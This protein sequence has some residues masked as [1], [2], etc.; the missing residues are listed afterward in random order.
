[1]KYKSLSIILLLG[2]LVGCYS[3]PAQEPVHKAENVSAPI[4][5]Q[6][7]VTAKDTSLQLTRLADATFGELKQP[8]ERQI[9]VF[10]DPGKTFQTMVG[11]GG[12]LT[13]ASA[14]VFAKLPPAVQQDFLTAYY[15]KEKGIGYNFARTNIGSCDFSSDSYGYVQE[16]DSTLQTF[17]LAHDEKYKIPFIKQAMTAAGGRL[18]LF[19]SPWSP[20]AWMKD[21][22]SLLHGGKLLKRF[23]QSWANHY[24]KFIQSYEA[25]GIPIWGLSVQNEP[26]AVQK[27]ES[28]V[29]NAEDERDFVKNYLGPTL[30]KNGLSDKKLIVWD[31]NRDLIYQRASVVLGDPEAEKYIWGIGFHWYETWTRSG[32]QFDN[33]RLVK[34]AFPKTNLIFSEGCVEKFNIDS[35]GNWS[36]GERYAHSM[37][38]DFNCGTVAWTDWNIL[39]DE[40]GGPNHVGNF[41]Y[42]PVHADVEKGKLLFTNS[43]FYIG[44]FSKFIQPG[45]KRI[46]CSANRD[47]LEATAFLNPDGKIVVV[48][49]NRSDEKLPM[50]LWIAGKAFET[51]SLPHSIITFVI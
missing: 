12:A 34:D 40:K 32:M 14:E 45:A 13:D 20:P 47:K 43:Y 19:V 42:A 39:L 7:F 23:N 22:N 10:V 16:N 36:L 50:N 49:L 37:V 51:N 3:R 1:M 15:S 29:Y 4:S 46:S 35:I 5:A 38:N 33:V 21:N 30:Q 48:V 44:H 28:C 6:I 9:C 31:H 17:S 25:L 8:N 27:W 26:M 18:P 2:T 24:V 11:I 41:C